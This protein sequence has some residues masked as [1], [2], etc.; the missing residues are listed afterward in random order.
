VAFSR[1]FESAALVVV[2]P[3]LV[4]SL[5]NKADQITLNPD[6]LRTGAVPLPNRLHGRRVASLLQPQH[7]ITG[8]APIPL[9]RLLSD[10][11][12][13]VLYAVDSA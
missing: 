13:A 2:V 12:A 10:V 4:R 5:V 9:D 1:L 7:G 3:R 6:R 8:E 11:P